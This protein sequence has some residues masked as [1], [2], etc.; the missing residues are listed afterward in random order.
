[1]SKTCPKRSLQVFIFVGKRSFCGLS[2]LLFVL[3]DLLH[4]ELDFGRCKS[5]GFHEGQVWITHQLPGQPQEGLLEVVVGLG[6][7]VII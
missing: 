2:Q 7:D 1:M 6:R 5:G 3:L 4:I